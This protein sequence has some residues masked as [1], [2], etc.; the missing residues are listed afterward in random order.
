MYLKAESD[1]LSVNTNENRAI[2][3]KIKKI[4]ILKTIIRYLNFKGNSPIIGY[5]NIP[6]IH[7]KRN[8]L[9]RQQLCC[10]WGNL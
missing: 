2:A 10:S 1:K 3:D 8:S 5:T 6:Y 9:L 4:I 7:N